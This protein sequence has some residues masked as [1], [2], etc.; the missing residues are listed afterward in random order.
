MKKILLFAAAAATI[1]T[2]AFAAPGDTA[3]ATGAA[4]AEVVAPITITHVS[5]ASLNFGKFSITPMIMRI[6]LKGTWP[7][8]SSNSGRLAVACCWAL[9]IVTTSRTPSNH[10]SDVSSCCL[11]KRPSILAH[12]RLYLLT[13]NRLFVMVIRCS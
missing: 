3:D 8:F 13:P 10:L 7:D 6:A 4:T 11:R 12:L 5:G 2:P 9:N 1:S